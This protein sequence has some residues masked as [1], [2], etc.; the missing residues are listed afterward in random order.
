MTREQAMEWAKTLKPGDKVIVNMGSY[1]DFKNI[2]VAQVKKVTP[3]LI[4][5]TDKGDFSLGKYATVYRFRGNMFYTLM[6]TTEGL[7]REAESQDERRVRER[8]MKLTVAKAKGAIDKV[9][10]RPMRYEFANELLS[11]LKKEYGADLV[12]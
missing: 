4:I 11:I 12:K 8:E 6:P 3:T 7:L 1:N 9:I 2:T 5:R 10:N